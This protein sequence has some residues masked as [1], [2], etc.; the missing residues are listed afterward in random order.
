MVTLLPTLIGVSATASERPVL[1]DIEVGKAFPTLWLPSADDGQP[2]SV[3]Q[4][5][6]SKLILHV[7]AS[8]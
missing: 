6:G 5:R 8:W 3:A 4:F 7:F 1:G 2:M